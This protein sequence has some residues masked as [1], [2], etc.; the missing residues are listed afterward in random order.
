ML[1]NMLHRSTKQVM[2]VSITNSKASSGPNTGWNVSRAS[3]APN[4]VNITIVN[5]MCTR[6]FRVPEVA[7]LNKRR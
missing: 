3:I 4:V 5:V 7:T 6:T 1:T 2:L